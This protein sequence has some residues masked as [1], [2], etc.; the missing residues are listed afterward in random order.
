MGGWTSDTKLVRV[1]KKHKRLVRLTKK[2]P[3]SRKRILQLSRTFRDGRLEFSRPKNDK[4]RVEFTGEES[5]RKVPT[6]FICGWWGVWVVSR[7]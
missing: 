2:S 1:D 3:E 4:S 5:F 6:D 7:R